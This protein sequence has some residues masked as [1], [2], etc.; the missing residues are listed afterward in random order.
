MTCDDMD[1]APKMRAPCSVG[2]AR[3]ERSRRTLTQRKVSRGNILPKDG[4]RTAFARLELGRVL[5]RGSNQ[6]IDTEEISAR[7]R[8]TA[9]G[10]RGGSNRSIYRELASILM[11]LIFRYSVARLSFSARAASVTRPPC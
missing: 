5:F 11:S 3:L 8:E 1:H 10:I 4:C 7:P 2:Q 9:N 6:P